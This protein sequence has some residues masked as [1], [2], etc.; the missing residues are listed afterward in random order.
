M[1]ASATAIT[2]RVRPSHK[3]DKLTERYLTPTIKGKLE[4]SRIWIID[5]DML[6]KTGKE[7]YSIDDFEKYAYNLKSGAGLLHIHDAIP[8]A[9]MLTQTEAAADLGVEV[10]GEFGSW[11]GLV[12]FLDGLARR[13]SRPGIDPG[14]LDVL[15][16]PISNSTFSPDGARLVEKVVEMVVETLGDPRVFPCVKGGASRLLVPLTDSR[17]S[18]RVVESYG[19]FRVVGGKGA[20]LVYPVDLEGLGLSAMG[21]GGRCGLAIRPIGGFLAVRLPGE[22]PGAT[23]LRDALDAFLRDLLSS[24][25]KAVDAGPF[26]SDDRGFVRFDVGDMEIGVDGSSARLADYALYTRAHTADDALLVL[27]GEEG[28]YAVFPAPESYIIVEAG[29][30]RLTLAPARHAVARAH[31]GAWNI[32]TAYV[33]SDGTVVTRVESDVGAAVPALDI[34]RPLCVD[35]EYLNEIRVLDRITSGSMKPPSLREYRVPVTARRIGGDGSVEEFGCGKPFSGAALGNGEAVFRNE[36]EG[37]P[38]M[39]QLVNPDAYRVFGEEECTAYMCMNKL[40][41]RAKWDR[42]PIGFAQFALVQSAW[43]YLYAG[44]VTSYYLLRYAPTM[45]S[46]GRLGYISYLPFYGGDMKYGEV[47]D[48]LERNWFPIDKFLLGFQIARVGGWAYVSGA[49]MIAPMYSPPSALYP[50]AQ[51]YIGVEHRSATALLDEARATYLI[52]VIWGTNREGAEPTNYADAPVEP[53]RAFAANQITLMPKMH[54]ADRTERADQAS[55]LASTANVNASA[56][57][58]QILLKLLQ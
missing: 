18:T 16:S 24:V 41:L 52:K 49:V 27:P 12:D 20:V 21:M 25:D 38:Y 31:I 56:R 36:V 47:R 30:G 8:V 45:F 44:D 3:L 48:A 4:E 28:Y 37:L 42:L 17:V 33:R 54:F 53:L 11:R 26:K 7:Y 22:S 46:R 39:L 40:G 1:M 57:I 58:L 35:G 13:G 55:A 2:I 6:T 5:E 23:G 43:L 14:V 51:L 34:V 29:D 50:T 15:F 9:A 19:R 10:P 32:D